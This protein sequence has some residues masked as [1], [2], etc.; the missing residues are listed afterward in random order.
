MREPGTDRRTKFRTQ[1]EID[2]AFSNLFDNVQKGAGSFCSILLIL[3]E[4][5]LGHT[6]FYQSRT[7][8]KC[9]DDGDDT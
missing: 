5:L 6:A 2:P 8:E 3:V 7:G 9:H 1:R 4:L